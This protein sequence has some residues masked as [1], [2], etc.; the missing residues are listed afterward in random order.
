MST[1]EDTLAAPFST[2]SICAGLCFRISRQSG[3]NHAWFVISDPQ[4]FPEE[5]LLYVNMTSFDPTKPLSFVYNDP[6]C[7]FDVGDHRLMTKPTCICYDDAHVCSVEHLAWRLT[8]DCDRGFKLERS[9]AAGN[10]LDKM[11]SGAANSQHLKPIHRK[12]L[13]D[14]GLI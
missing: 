9:P 3:D 1:Q 14:Q 4:V 5:N 10:I 2:D 8:T 13:E 6:S 11:R 12:I 7:V